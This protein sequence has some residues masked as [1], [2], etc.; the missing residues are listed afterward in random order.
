M[1]SRSNIKDEL[2][3]EKVGP[4]QIQSIAERAESLESDVRFA[5]LY[6][7]QIRAL[8]V[9]TIRKFLNSKTFLKPDTF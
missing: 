4:L 9:A 7:A 6:T 5:S 3:I 1:R 8:H 2:R